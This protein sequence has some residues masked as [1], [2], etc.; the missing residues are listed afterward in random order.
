MLIGDMVAY[1]IQQ[2][3]NTAPMRALDERAQS[4]IAA[5]TWLDTVVIRYVVTVAAGAF[6]GRNCQRQLMPRS[7]R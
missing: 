3:A 7:A 1:Q 6:P 2:D 4:V 5:Q